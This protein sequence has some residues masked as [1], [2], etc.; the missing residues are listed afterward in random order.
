MWNVD[1]MQDAH[2][3]SIHVTQSDPD[4]ITST[5]LHYKGAEGHRVQTYRLAVRQELRKRGLPVTL[6]S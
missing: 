5:F 2:I 6:G 3:Q 1:H 4:W